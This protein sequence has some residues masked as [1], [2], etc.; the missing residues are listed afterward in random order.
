MSGRQEKDLGAIRFC[1]LLTAF[2]VCFLGGPAVCRAQP[3]PEIQ[4]T[5]RFSRTASIST[6]RRFPEGLPP[7][8]D[9]KER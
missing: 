6:T 8:A 4:E 3:R 5:S 7:S 9:L 1:F 2:A